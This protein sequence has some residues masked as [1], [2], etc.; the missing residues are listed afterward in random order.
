L[1]GVSEKIKRI[2]MKCLDKDKRLNEIIEA[3][4]EGGKNA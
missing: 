1:E 4:E 2:V 3:L